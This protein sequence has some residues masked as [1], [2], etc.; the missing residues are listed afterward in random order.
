[1]QLPRGCRKPDSDKGLTFFL[2]LLMA[3]FPCLDSVYA[4]TTVS[5]SAVKDN[6]LYQSNTGNLSDGKGE[7]LFIG[8]TN[9]NTTP[10]GLI[11]RAILK[12]DVA[13]S[14]PAN[15]TITSAS[16]IMNMN[17]TSMTTA[18]N[19]TVH[20]VN[21]D[22]GEGNSN[23]TSNEGGGAPSQTNDA[24]WIH[25]F[26][27]STNWTTAGGDFNP[28][29][30]ASTNVGA[31]GIYTWTSAQLAADVQNW[32]NNPATNFGWIILGNETIIH[33]AKRFNSREH[34]TVA[35]RP[36]LSVTYTIP[37]V[38]PVVT[39]FVSDEPG[40][41]S[42]ESVQL[43]VTGSLN[44]A[45]AWHLYTGG[46]GTTPVASNATG[47]FTVS[48]SS[49]ITYYVRGEGGCITPGT[50]SEVTV[51]V[52][53]SGDPSFN[54]S[55]MS[56]CAN[57]PNPTPV[58]TGTPGGTFSAAPAGLAIDPSTGTIDLSASPPSGYMIKY[59]TDSE[60]PASAQYGIVIL[61][62]PSAELEHSI[63]EGN[64]FQFGTQTLTEEGVYTEVFTHSNGCDS[65]VTLTF[66]VVPVLEGETEVTI[67]EG[68]SYEFGTQTLTVAGEYTETF[69]SVSGCDSVVTL[70]L[71]IN[72][73]F[74]EEEQI[75]ICDG[76]EFVFG[77]Q[78]LNIAGEYTEEFIS[79]TGCDSI[80]TLTLNV[81]A[82]NT[83][84]IQNDITLTAEAT[85]A[86]FQWVDCN[87]E[88]APVLNE[89]N[90]SFTPEANGNYAV[91]VTQNGC[92]LVSPCFEVVIVGLEDLIT[93][94]PLI[95]PNPVTNQLTINLGELHRNVMIEII[96]I[97]G[98]AVGSYQFT[99]RK[100]IDLDFI[101]YSQGLYIIKIKTGS[102][103][104]ILKILKQ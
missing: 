12:F 72:P 86:T 58:I 61:R 35:L 49:A 33:T 100:T 98:Q 47:V 70:T 63:C 52:T 43:T 28:T 22:W 62:T 101:T 4:Q 13:A 80:V 44:S 68:N 17:R 20:T 32:L 11:R 88:Y 81:N 46:C 93:A 95:Y 82:V 55:Q 78:L 103:T 21:A 42:G 84:V 75:T 51:S 41:C 15:A 79:V 59:E 65:T 104:Q 85:E 1:M 34:P 8:R 3:F 30:S 57:D 5:L 29:P 76:E 48:P 91:E 74:N 7:F 18:H 10:D 26:F 9:A 60:C 25:R 87:N 16:L 40:I 14:I 102:G 96:N 19:T 24:T 2:S 99:S 89:T 94:R 77:S 67:C 23:G 39:S 50:C 90:S 53:A 56:Y 69:Q 54:Y 73:A 45:T 27:P 71:N 97:H 83:N 64:S 37:C 36:Q 6:T 31:I 66:H 92:M 38:D